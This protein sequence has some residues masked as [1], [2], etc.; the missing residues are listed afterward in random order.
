MRIWTLGLS[1]G[2]L[3]TLTSCTDP[4]V[5]ADREILDRVT[6]PSTFQ[7]I[8]QY[9]NQGG[10]VRQYLV[11]PNDAVPDGLVAPATFAELV[12]TNSLQ[13]LTKASGWKPLVMWNTPSPR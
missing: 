10:V 9:Q 6:S 11:D 8:N 2:L 12:P 7:F 4:F 3:L 13:N 5:A 1:L